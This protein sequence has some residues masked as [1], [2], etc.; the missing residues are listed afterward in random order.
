MTFATDNDDLIGYDDLIG[1]VG[2]PVRKKAKHKNR[3]YYSPDIVD[4]IMAEIRKGKPLRI[5][6]KSDLDRYPSVKGF[7]NW[8]DRYD[9]WDDYNKAAKNPEPITIDVAKEII[10]RVANG[11]TLKQVLA[12]D[13]DFPDRIRFRSFLKTRPELQAEFNE[14]QMLRSESLAD[15]LEDIADESEN[16]W[17]T[18]K[19][20][21]PVVN[22]EA[23]QRSKLRVETK[24]W[25]AGVENA[26][27]QSRNTTTLTGANDTPLI[28]QNNDLDVARRVAFLLAQ[29]IT[30]V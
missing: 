10:Y 30:Q 8:L 27:F 15:E 28:P 13:P 12:S 22:T 7:Y 26:K 24:K 20:G 29:G 21:N 25:R 9:L 2:K 23:I 14:A 3:N 4:E 16:D 6:L 5:V 1:D 17:T 18:D 19:H 11:E